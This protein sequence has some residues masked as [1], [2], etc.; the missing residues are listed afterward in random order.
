MRSMEDGQYPLTQPGTPVSSPVTE[1]G[2]VHVVHVSIL[3][4][5]GVNPRLIRLNECQSAGF[6]F[7]HV[8]RASGSVDMAR[9]WRLGFADIVKCCQVLG[10][11]SL[12]FLF[13]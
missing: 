8:V 7:V 10:A 5:T 4:L 11:A 12:L 1:C 2:L 6:D 3:V 9:S 13:N